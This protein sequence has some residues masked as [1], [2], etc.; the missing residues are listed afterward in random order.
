MAFFLSTSTPNARM[1]LFHSK[2]PTTSAL[3]LGLSFKVCAELTEAFRVSFVLS[4]AFLT[5]FIL[6]RL[7]GLE[8]CCQVHSFH[9]Q[10]GYHILL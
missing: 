4:L 8:Q 10:V 5:G 7:L 9:A 3:G 2:Y 1:S 6:A